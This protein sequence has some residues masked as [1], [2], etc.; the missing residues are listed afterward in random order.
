MTSQEIITLQKALSKLT[1]FQLKLTGV[2]DDQT[3]AAIK[4]YQKAN[5]LQVDGI[6][7]PITG[8]SIA[9]KINPNGIP[10]VLAGI[11]DCTNWDM[12]VGGWVMPKN[13]MN[14]RFF[15]QPFFPGGG[16]GA[17]AGNNQQLSCSHVQVPV[18]P[19]VLAWVTKGIEAIIKADPTGKYFAL[20]I[21]GLTFGVDSLSPLESIEN[22]LTKH[23][24]E[25]QI[26]SEGLFAH[27]NQGA[28]HAILYRNA[29]AGKKLIIMG[30]SMGG[31]EVVPI[32]QTLNREYALN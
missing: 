12:P 16:R 5:N 7:G 30:H 32:I 28:N 22:I 3:K 2:M 1:T 4:A 23:N 17:L 31:D 13:C 20:L 26:V 18:D 8:T 6:V 9:S 24:V 15:Y 19:A 11:L 29:I 25:C 21:R 14:Y 27:D 10:V